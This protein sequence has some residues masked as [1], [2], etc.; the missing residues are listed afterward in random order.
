MPL[1]NSD[2]V[3]LLGRHTSPQSGLWVYCLQ[4]VEGLLADSELVLHCVVGVSSGTSQRFLQP[5][6]ELMRLYPGRIT[7]EVFAA[8][9]GSR[10]VGLLTDVW[11]LWLNGLIGRYKTRLVHGL[12]NQVPFLPGVPSVVTLHDTFQAFPPVAVHGLYLR[13]RTLIYRTQYQT[14]LR[15]ATLLLTLSNQ[16]ADQFQARFGGSLNIEVITPP[17]KQVGSKDL[18]ASSAHREDYL[19]AFAS[20][21]PRKNVSMLIEAFAN[22]ISN[23]STDFGTLSLCV[24]VSG[25]SLLQQL[26]DSAKSFGISHR[27]RFDIGLSDKALQDLMVRARG[28]AFVSL[29]EGFGYPIYEALLL[30]LPVLGPESLLID[31]MRKKL[32]SA[33]LSPY[34]DCNCRDL[35]AI[36]EGLAELIRRA[37]TI[38]GAALQKIAREFFA[39]LEFGKSLAK[40]YKKVY[41]PKE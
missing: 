3:L 10:R 38:D 32:L 34:V 5:L 36:E 33:G 37:E 19:V 16:V 41:A 1:Y 14:T 39:T 23:N 24:V 27:V 31:E 17:P 35:K 29:G 7:V 4:V 21:D 6:N 40:A 30:G 15:S 9:L 26:K 28:L 22:L 12:V 20:D 8:P 11:R 25:S 2:V 13:V 18:P